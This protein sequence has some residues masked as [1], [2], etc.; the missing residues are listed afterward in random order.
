MKSTLH[1]NLS[2]L[3]LNETCKRVAFLRPSGTDFTGMV[4]L[5]WS[6]F[7]FSSGLF[8]DRLRL[9]GSSYGADWSPDCRFLAYESEGDILIFDTK[10]HTSARTQH[11][12][13]PVWSPDGRTIMFRAPWGS[14]SFVN[15][16]GAIVRS[17]LDNHMALGAIQCSPDG[18]YV[19]FTE[20]LPGPHIPLFGATRRLVVCRFQDGACMTVREFGPINAYEDVFHWILGYRGFCADCNPAEP[21]N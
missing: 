15:P 20:E 4:D 13:N 21:L 1:S 5:R 17:S 11:G 10:N 3:S 7:D 14:V 8:I 18:K 12:H 19:S 2:L 9:G 6:S 16:Q